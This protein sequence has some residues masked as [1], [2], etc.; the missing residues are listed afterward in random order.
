MD[1][2]VSVPFLLF[3]SSFLTCVG[4]H[5]MSR[6]LHAMS[7]RQPAHFLFFSRTRALT[8]VVIGSAAYQKAVKISYVRGTQAILQSA[9]L[10]MLSK[11]QRANR[12]NAALKK[13]G[14]EDL[15]VSTACVWHP[16]CA[17]CVHSHSDLAF[18]FFARASMC[19][20]RLHHAAHACVRFF[21]AFLTRKGTGCAR[22]SLFLQKKGGRSNRSNVAV[23]DAGWAN[24]IPVHNELGASPPSL[25]LVILRTFNESSLLGRHHMKHLSHHGPRFPFFSLFLFCA[26]LLEPHRV[27]AGCQLPAHDWHD[28]RSEPENMDTRDGMSKDPFFAMHAPFPSL[29]PPLT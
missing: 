24:R 9:P 26:G 13:G 16:N 25:P 8:M 17:A 28:G 12:V 27:G 22:L 29:A 19:T 7:N 10:M 4:A 5:S 23:R 21:L 20:S 11:S 3:S 15:K 1:R 6:V 18:L 2:V 14:I